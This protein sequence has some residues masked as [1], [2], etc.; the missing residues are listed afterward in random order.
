MNDFWS[1]KLTLKIRFWHF[2]TAIFGHLT[3]LMKKSNSFLWSVQLYLQSEMFLSNSVDVMKNLPKLFN[4]VNRQ[5]PSKKFLTPSYDK[6]PYCNFFFARLGSLVDVKVTGRGQ[7]FFPHF[8]WRE[9]NF[10]RKFLYSRALL[11]RYP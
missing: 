11:V 5:T 7:V 1:W 2:L 10:L 9:G 3:S 4:T 6:L 8:F